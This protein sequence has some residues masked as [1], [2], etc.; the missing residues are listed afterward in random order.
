MEQSMTSEEPVSSESPTTKKAMVLAD[1]ATTSA[2][3]KAS[4]S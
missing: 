3:E 4:G 1:F 2:T